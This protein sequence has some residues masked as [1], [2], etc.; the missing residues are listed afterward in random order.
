MGDCK[1]CICTRSTKYKRIIKKYG[2]KGHDKI[3]LDNVMNLTVELGFVL[4]SKEKSKLRFVQKLVLG[5]TSKLVISTK[6]PFLPKIVP[7]A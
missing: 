4:A 5:V 3:F 7:G 1:C 2:I 6:H